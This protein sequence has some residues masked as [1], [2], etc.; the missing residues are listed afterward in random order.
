M[1]ERDASTVVALAIVWSKVR[2]ADA[3]GHVHR[4]VVGMDVS[5]DPS[6][7]S[8]APLYPLLDRARQYGL[9]VTIHAGEVAGREEVESVL[10][11]GPDRLG[12]MCVLPEGMLEQ[13]QRTAGKGSIPIELCP[14]SNAFTLGLGV[15][16]EGA[17]VEAGGDSE[18]AHAQHKLCKH[19]TLLP[20]LRSGYPL[21][22]CTDDWG[23]F[24]TSLSQELAHVVTAAGWDIEDNGEGGGAQRLGELVMAGF[25]HA[26]LQDEQEVRAALLQAA[27]ERVLQVLRVVVIVPA[28]GP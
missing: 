12:H 11:W 26:F 6:K 1:A 28:S 9:R 13:L 5:G 18:Y 21:A 7:G 4:L 3:A 22:V 16:A 10:A 14:T 2:W 15:S 25:Q 20:L 23:V 24:S 17:E 27:A 19:P 8:L